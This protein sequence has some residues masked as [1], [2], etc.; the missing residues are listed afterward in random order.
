MDNEHLDASARKLQQAL[1]EQ[2]QVNEGGLHDK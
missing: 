2:L 1:D